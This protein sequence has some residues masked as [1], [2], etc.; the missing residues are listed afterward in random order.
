V[1]VVEKVGSKLTLDDGHD[2]ALLDSRGTLETV[3]VDTTEELSLQVHVVE[4]V[5]GLIVVGLDL[6]CAGSACAQTQTRT[7]CM[8]APASL[9]GCG[10]LRSSRKSRSNTQRTA[11]ATA[12]HTQTGRLTL[13]HILKTFVSHDCEWSRGRAVGILWIPPLLDSRVVRGKS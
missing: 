6:A 1:V 8:L 4:G 7:F 5:G 11:R 3:G 13:G 12:Q 2:G 10:A 9:Y